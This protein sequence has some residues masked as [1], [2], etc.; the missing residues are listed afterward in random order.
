SA[1]SSTH[2][3]AAWASSRRKALQTLPCR[4][5]KGTGSVIDQLTGVGSA[6]EGSSI[7]K[8]NHF[9]WSLVIVPFSFSCLSCSSSNLPSD[10]L[11]STLRTTQLKYVGCPNVG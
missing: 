11:S 1:G 8:P 4:R 5:S 9:S 2:P 3:R 6:S 10:A 7:G